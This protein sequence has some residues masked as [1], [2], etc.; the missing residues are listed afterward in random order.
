MDLLSYNLEQAFIHNTYMHTKRNA[1][2]YKNDLFKDSDVKAR[3]TSLKER[4][5]HRVCVEIHLNPFSSQVTFL[6]RSL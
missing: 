1:V 2:S 3:F 4:L 5:M 6:F